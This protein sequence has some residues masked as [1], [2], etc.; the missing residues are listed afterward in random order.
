[1]KRIISAILL[2]ALLLTACGAGETV[3]QEAAAG[4]NVPSG[5]AAEP[6][7]EPPVTVKT[8][9]SMELEHAIYDPSVERFTYFIHNDSGEAVEFGEEY[10]IQRWENGA[11]QALKAKG[12]TAWNAIAYGLQP[13]GTMARTC[14]FGMYKEKPTAGRYRLVKAVGGET[15]YAEF[16]L[17]ESIYTSNTPYGFEALEMLPL[18]Y[19]AANA[20]GMDMLFTNDGVTNGGAAEE[21]LHKVGMGASCQLRTVQDYGENAPMVTD[22]IYEKDCFLWRM[23]SGGD[24]IEKRFSYIVTDGADLYLANGADWENTLAYG[25]DKTLLLPEGAETLLAAAE[26]QMKARLEGD[27]TRYQVWWSDE[28]AGGLWSAG[29]WDGEPTTFSVSWHSSGGGGWGSSFNLQN[30]DG[31]ETAIR[32]LAWQAD[33]KLLLTCDTVNGG[34]SRLCF[35]PESETLQNF[36]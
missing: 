1:M 35:D 4:E 14:G 31:L 9:V 24:I 19:S 16:E 15:L 28:T 26:E 5:E 11:W 25:S 36:G 33:G 7:G 34:V 12:D 6:V 20:S 10:A 29:L 13:G 30:W 32:A 2:L 21:F 18:D 27:I 3:P 23:W 17:G 8:P 22:I